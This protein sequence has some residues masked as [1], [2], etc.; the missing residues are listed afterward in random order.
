MF[1]TVAPETFSKKSRALFYE[2]LPVSLAAHALFAAWFV[3][4][5]IWEVKFPGQSPRLIVAYS[6]LTPPP[7]PPPPPP[8]QPKVVQQVVPVQRPKEIVAPT[9]I[10]DEI[11]VVPETEP[12]PSPVVAEGVEGGIEGGVVAGVVGGE[13]GGVE[14]GVIGGITGGELDGVI[15]VERDKKLPMY[16]VS[17]V[18]P[19]YPE[20]ARLRG[21][22]DTVV[23]R[24]RIGTNGRVK[25][26]SVI[27]PA[28]RKIFEEVAM[29]AIR[30][31]RFRP[32]VKDGKPQEV[33]HELTVYFRLES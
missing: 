6:L 21:W 19:A 16:P 25:E 14:G 9:V 12:P 23:V 2:T 32:L 24:Y 5:T 17:Q 20:Q 28:E 8:A 31:W 10:P 13:T 15:T 3:V 4:A 7:P 18:Y 26:V 27:S 30:N 33:V 22:E 11:P 1:E 29:K